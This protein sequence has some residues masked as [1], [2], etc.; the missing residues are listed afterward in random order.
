[1]TN[2]YLFLMNIFTST[3]F[4]I[5]NI[6]DN[7]YY[8][9]YSDVNIYYQK[10]CKNINYLLKNDKINYTRFYMLIKILPLLNKY[11]CNKI[12]KIIMDL[13]LLDENYKSKKIYLNS[14]SKTI[15][16]S[17]IFD[18]KIRFLCETLKNDKYFINNPI[19]YISNDCY[20]NNSTK[21]LLNII[22]C[23]FMN[24]LKLIDYDDKKTII[25]EQSTFIIIG[26]NIHLYNDLDYIDKF[27]RYILISDS[28]DNNIMWEKI[29]VSNLL[30]S[31]NR[32]KK[33]MKFMKD[34][35]KIIYIDKNY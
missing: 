25:P 34:T 20:N 1:M 14:I 2:I 33:V 16:N 26:A 17:L 3:Q 28:F 10:R 24:S 21:N 22:N 19:L 15:D 4:F 32:Y 27:K 8:N 23:Y 7:I 30:N 31:S 6:I 35:N 13:V 5:E 9:V 29:G 11:T 18:Y 12:S